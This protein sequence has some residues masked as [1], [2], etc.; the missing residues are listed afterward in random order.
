MR[1]NWDRL[2]HR[3]VKVECP[4][5]GAPMV[6]PGDE[7]DSDQ[8][9]YSLNSCDDCCDCDRYMAMHGRE[10]YGEDWEPGDALTEAVQD[11]A[12]GDADWAGY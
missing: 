5:C 2:V 6:V 11:A 1:F 7:V 12:F 9:R 8:P 4:G 10:L 3:H